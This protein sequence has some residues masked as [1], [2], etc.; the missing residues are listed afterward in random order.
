MHIDKR[1]GGRKKRKK[2]TRKERKEGRGEERKGERGREKEREREGKERTRQDKGKKQ[3]KKRK[4]KQYILRIGLSVIIQICG[5]A[6]N[7]YIVRALKMTHNPQ[8]LLLPQQPETTVTN[9]VGA[10]M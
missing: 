8:S 6:R 4:E 9:P 10:V 3:K 2:Q 7:R 5:R 1:K